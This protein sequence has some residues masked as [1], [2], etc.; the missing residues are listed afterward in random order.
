MLAEF[1]M[2]LG[3]EALEVVGGHESGLEEPERLKTIEQGMR[4]DLR[5][6][7]TSKLL[8]R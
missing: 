5:G 3:D 1:N 6:Q 2:L 7:N 4:V 8:S